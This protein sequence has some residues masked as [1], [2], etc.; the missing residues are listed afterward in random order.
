MDDVRPPSRAGP[1][2]RTC[3]PNRSCSS[4]ADRSGWLTV[5]FTCSMKPVRH[6]DR[7]FDSG[8]ACGLV[9]PQAKLR[10]SHC[11]GGGNDARQRTA[12]DRR[13]GRA[14]RPQRLRDPL[15]R[16]EGAGAGAAHVGRAAA[17]PALRHPPPVLRPD[18][19]ADRPAPFPRSP[20]SS[21]QLPQGR[22]PTPEPTGG[23]SAT[24][25]A[26]CSTSGSRRCSGCATRSTAASAAAASR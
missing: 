25:S 23:G 24:A 8:H 16:G 19:A 12:G 9:Q 26:T 17:L 18:R 22:T 6:D 20:P 7:P 11:C 4:F 15:L 3:Q 21:R 1:C 2:Q 5:M 10:S 14:D 13:A